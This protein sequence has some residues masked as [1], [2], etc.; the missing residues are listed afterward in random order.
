VQDKFVS[1]TMKTEE[2]ANLARIRE[3]KN[4]A[5]AG[6]PLE[7][8]IASLLRGFVDDTDLSSKLQGLYKVLNPQISKLFSASNGIIKFQHDLRVSW[9]PRADVA[10]SIRFFHTENGYERR[11]VPELRRVLHLHQAPGG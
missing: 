11:R 7:P 1:H 2:E 8:L 10:C 3:E 5:D 9:A 4:K 6:N